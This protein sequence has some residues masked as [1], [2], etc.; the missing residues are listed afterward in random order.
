MGTLRDEDLVR[1]IGGWSLA[2]LT[3]ALFGTVPLSLSGGVMSRPGIVSPSPDLWTGLIVA[4]FALSGAALIQLRP[5][6]WIGWIL[7]V[8]GLLQVTNVAVDAYATRA[9]T[10]PDQSLPLGLAAAWLASWTWIPSL[11]LPV[12]VLPPLYPTGRP[13]SAYWSW[14]VRMA[15]IGIGLVVLVAATGQGGVDDTVPGTRLP[16]E[17]PAW[18]VWAVGLS[19]AIL[20]ISTA[21]VTVVGTLVRAIRAKTPERQ[22]L[23]WLLSVVAAMLATVFTEYRLLFAIAYG[24][25]PVAVTIGVLRYRLLGIEVALRRTLLY[26]PLTLLVAL[27]VGGLTTAFARLVP[28]GPVPLLIASAVVAVLVI[29]ASGRLRTLVDRLVLGE[30]ADPLALVDRVGAGLEID[31][32]DPV[33][34]ML[35]AVAS[36]AGTSYTVVRDVNGRLVAEVGSPEGAGLDLPLRHRGVQLGTLTVG[37]RRGASQVTEQ[38]GRL[39]AALA[40]HLA[41]VIRSARLAE[42]LARERIRVTTATLA[43][44][45]RLRRDLHDGLGPSLAGIALGLQAAGTAHRTD[46]DAVPSLLERTRAEAELAV[47]EIRRVL[48]GLRPSSLDLHG[49]EGA[50]RD[51]AASLGMGEAGG[52]TFDLQAGALP[53][54]P[55]QVEEAAFRIVAESLTNVARHSAAS[56][57]TVQLNQANGDLRV[58]VC[59]DGRGLSSLAG[60]GHGLDSMRKRA[61]EIGG[62]VCVEIAN[63]QGT[64]VT[65]VLPLETP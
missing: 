22:Q 30:R 41:V 23:L 17:A 11:L 4:G 15:L 34:A 6:N 20:L 28:E 19:A 49:L 54:L 40:P 56:H 32:D 53:A 60:S 64:L 47:S 39:V 5:R 7:V 57:C 52:P 18:W 50:V 45:D 48:D 38:D 35:E 51:T 12:I 44:R 24:L 13:A 55:P 2:A 14:H 62:T 46:P 33:A 3:L 8:S 25:V 58:R 36:A 65:A 26:V 43:E 27:V 31:H 1:R 9:L 10:D 21:A 37:P 29:P 42:E 16:W 59:D 61:T 63:P